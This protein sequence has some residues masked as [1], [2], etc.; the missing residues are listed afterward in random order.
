MGS[1]GNVDVAKVLAATPTLTAAC[2]R[3][4]QLVDEVRRR[5]ARGDDPEMTRA[6]VRSGRLTCAEALEQVDYFEMYLPRDLAARVRAA[7]LEFERT[8]EDAPSSGAAS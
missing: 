7:C 8:D 3:L 5:S 2:A 6:L 4:E 1:G